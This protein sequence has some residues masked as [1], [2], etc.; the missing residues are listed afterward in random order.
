MK[1]MK[2]WSKK[3]WFNPYVVAIIFLIISILIKPIRGFT[4]DGIKW[5][6]DTKIKEFPIWIF[7][8]ILA[9]LVYA[10]V[11]QKQKNNRRIN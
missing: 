8:P 7:I 11:L 4:V 10:S 6:F 2:F 9:I 3:F 1:K 5:I